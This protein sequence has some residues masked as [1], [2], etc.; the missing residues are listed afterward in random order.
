[1]LN[2]Y[3]CDFDTWTLKR[4]AVCVCKAGGDSGAWGCAL[5]INP[6]DQKATDGNVRHFEITGIEV[7]GCIIGRIG[8][9][10]FVVDILTYNGILHSP[11]HV[12]YMIPSDIVGIAVDEIS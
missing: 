7:D 1:L 10:R 12:R 11:R 9:E 2:V 4:F 8:E 5:S 6:V 3:A